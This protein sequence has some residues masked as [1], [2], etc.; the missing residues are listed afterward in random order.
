[1]ETLT[2]V[3]A[4]AMVAYGPRVLSGIIALVVGWLITKGLVAAL[5]GVLDRSGMDRTLSVFFG[6]L[7]YVMLMALVVITALDRFGCPAISFAA[8]VGAAGLAVGLAL[9]GT[10]S[11]LAAG[12]LLISLRP[13]GI[14]DRIDAAGVSGLVTQIHV[15]ATT[16]KTSDDKR[17]IVPNSSITGGNITVHPDA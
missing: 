15:F 1:M 16:I 9:K 10:L 14:G 6:N 17:V 7:T 11:N 4:T 3:I 2:E 8:V 5:K 13:F 12:V